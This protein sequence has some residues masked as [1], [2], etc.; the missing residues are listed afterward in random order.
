MSIKHDG[1]EVRYLGHQSVQSNQSAFVCLGLRV[2]YQHLQEQ[3]F[4]VYHFLTTFIK[5]AQSAQQL[6]SSFN[7]LFLLIIG[8]L[9]AD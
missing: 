9:Q 2:I 8:R 5:S 3:V 7:Q 6:Q 4:R 1:A